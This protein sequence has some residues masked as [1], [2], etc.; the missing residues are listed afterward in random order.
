MFNTSLTV[1]ID[2]KGRHSTKINMNNVFTWLSIFNSFY[3]P[4]CSIGLYG[5]NCLQ[6]CSMACGI[7]GNCDRITGYCQGGCQR[8]WTGVRCE[9]GR[10]CIN[11]KSLINIHVSYIFFTGYTLLF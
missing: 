3:F 1:L 10:R 9:E 4:E 11:N 5:V 6:N 2:F 8:G 7:P